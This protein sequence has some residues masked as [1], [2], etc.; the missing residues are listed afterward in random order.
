MY[1]TDKPEQ[2]DLLSPEQQKQLCSWIKENFIPIK[3]F[4]PKAES[5][6]LHATFE[7]SPNGFYINNGM[8]KQAMKQCG[9]KVKDERQQNWIFN[10]SI[11]SPA[12]A[13]RQT[14]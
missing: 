7:H 2:F 5:Y 3:T 11:K 9:F 8:F 1:E 4:N 14:Y 10:V 6:F 13:I 12:F